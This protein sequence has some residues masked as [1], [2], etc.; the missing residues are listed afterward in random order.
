MK[1][2]ETLARPLF[3]ELEIL[4]RRSPSK[5]RI[6]LNGTTWLKYSLSVWNDI[7]KSETEQRLK[8]PAIFPAQLARRLIEAFSFEEDIVLDPF[9]GTG[10]TL[11]A[12]EEL[13]RNS[14][15]IDISDE[16]IKISKTRLSETPSFDN[17]SK[18]AYKLI[19]DTAENIKEYIAPNTIGLCLT[20]PP[21]WDILTQKRTADYKKIKTYGG[22]RNDLGEIHDYKRFL[23]ALKSIMADVFDVLAKGKYCC[24]VVMDLRKKDKFYP[25]HMDVNAFMTNDIGFE[26]DDIIIWDRGREYNNL[27]PLG[28]PYVFRVNKIHEYILIFKK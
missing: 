10:S 28:H 9:V 4:K 2:N 14:I 20:S 18:P 6:D 16:F 11:V 8:H 24:M 15:G 19:T 7:K 27:R 3:K 25:F 17:N 22:H 12:A 5:R 13:G 26:L 1:K 21:Y 23:A